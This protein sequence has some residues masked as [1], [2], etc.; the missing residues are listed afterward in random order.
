MHTENIEILSASDKL[1]YDTVN[2][3]NRIIWYS[4]RGTIRRD[5]YLNIYEAVGN[6][7]GNIVSGYLQDCEF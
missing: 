6:S 3:F 4:A 7:I 2:G 1:H 5:V